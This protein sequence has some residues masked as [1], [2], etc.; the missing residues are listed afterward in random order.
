MTL[1]QK[2][3][4]SH[5]NMLR[6]ADALD[7]DGLEKSWQDAEVAFAALM[8]I[9]LNQ[10]TG[11]ERSEVRKL[12]EN[13]LELQKLIS[14]QVKPWLEQVRPLLESFERYPLTSDNT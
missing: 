9:P 14:G 11:N 10:L 6:M 3:N 4:D 5:Q 2:L 1:L 12:I 7:W 8:K 13:L